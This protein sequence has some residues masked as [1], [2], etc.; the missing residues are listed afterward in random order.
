MEAEFVS[1]LAAPL[2]RCGFILSR[3]LRRAAACIDDRE[4]ARKMALVGVS[5]RSVQKYVYDGRAYY[6]RSQ[7]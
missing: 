2:G 3:F 4:N 1:P 7:R 5:I 6:P